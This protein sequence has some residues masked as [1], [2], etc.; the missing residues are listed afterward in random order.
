ME[1]THVWRKFW[2]AVTGVL[3][4]A[5]FWWWT[6]SADG[7]WEV[8]FWVCAFVITLIALHDIRGFFE[9]LDRRRDIERERGGNA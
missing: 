9:E 4:T 7:G 8:V 6:Y 2:T 5:L 3:V 1:R